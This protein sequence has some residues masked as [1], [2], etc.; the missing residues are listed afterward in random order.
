[1]AIKNAS[2]RLEVAVPPERITFCV[3]HK[4]IPPL[5]LFLRARSVAVAALA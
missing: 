1:M 5:E 3:L 2:S 4:M